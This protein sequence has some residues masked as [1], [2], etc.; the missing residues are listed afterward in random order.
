MVTTKTD[1]TFEL[2]EMPAGSLQIKAIKDG[3]EEYSNYIGIKSGQTHN[4]NIIME[5]LN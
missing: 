5:P 1:G 4:V 3:Y 2:K